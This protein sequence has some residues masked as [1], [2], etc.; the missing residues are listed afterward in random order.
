MAQPATQ[1]WL[2][3]LRG[4]SLR[5]LP[6]PH[7]ITAAVPA[8]AGAGSQL[9]Q[10]QPAGGARRQ[11]L[12]TAAAAAAPPGDNGS[13][14]VA[15]Q[16]RRA[17]SGKIGEAGGRGMVDLNP[18]RGTRDFF[19]EDKRLQNWLFD[20]FAA[21]SRLFGFEQIDFPVLESGECVRSTRMSTPGL[22]SA[23]AGRAAVLRSWPAFL[24]P[25]LLSAAAPLHTVKAEEL[26]VRKA[27]EE[28]TDQLYNFEDKG[29]RRVTLRP[30]LTPSLARLALQ[31]GGASARRDG[32]H[33][34]CTQAHSRWVYSALRQRSRP[35]C[36]WLVTTSSCLPLLLLAIAARDP[37]GAPLPACAPAE[38]Q[39]PGPP[40]QVVLHRPVLALRAGHA[41]AAAR[42]LPMEHGHHRGGG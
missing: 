1:Q 41:R 20:E 23:Y 17:G 35:G 6:S 18:P 26:Y 12:R 21:V 39:G 37:P 19:P 10:R 28:I 24:P 33:A 14:A 8:A 16:E 42:T 36:E 25:C 32:A 38:G 34:A 29:G 11:R 7:T 9:R 30:E 3:A 15:T 31:V 22:R 2:V 5:V 13:A 27:G 40:R 4:S